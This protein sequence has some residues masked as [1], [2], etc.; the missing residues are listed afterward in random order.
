M[1]TA[2]ERAAKFEL[3]STEENFELNTAFELQQLGA[4]Y[5]QYLATYESLIIFKE[6]ESRV[7]RVLEVTTELVKAD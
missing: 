7:K 5:W 4:A 6:N 3:K 1:A 2:F